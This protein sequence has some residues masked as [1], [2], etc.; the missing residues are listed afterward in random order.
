MGNG[1]R[2]NQTRSGHFE[3]HVRPFPVT[4]SGGEEVASV[5]GGS[6]PL[7]SPDGRELFYLAVDGSLMRVGVGSGPRWTPT[8]PT[9]VLEPRYFAG[10][11]TVSGRPYD[12]SKDG[13]RFLMIK[14]DSSPAPVNF[15][16][17][18]HFDEELKAR[19][20]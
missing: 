13:K 15:V 5:G 8:P 9:R 7:W 4:E 1:S 16:V 6:R 10:D 20:K 2:I 17:V 18:Q 11:N 3:I 19:V 12:I 14:R